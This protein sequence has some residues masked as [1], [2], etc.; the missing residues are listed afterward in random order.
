MDPSVVFVLGMGSNAH[1]LGVS[2]PSVVNNFTIGQS[3]CKFCVFYAV[4]VYF[5]PKIANFSINTKLV[6]VDHVHPHSL[7]NGHLTK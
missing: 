7:Q 5:T 1:W 6:S 4:G 2:I 3:P